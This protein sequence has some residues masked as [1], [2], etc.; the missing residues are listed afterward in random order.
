MNKQRI[1]TPDIVVWIIAA[2][3]AARL[4]WMAA[5]Y[6]TPLYFTIVIGLAFLTASQSGLDTLRRALTASRDV[7]AGGQR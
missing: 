6:G 1:A 2:I 7:P 5:R 3:I 4:A